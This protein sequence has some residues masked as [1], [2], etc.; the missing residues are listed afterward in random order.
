[1]ATNND[2]LFIN[3]VLTSSTSYGTVSV[4]NLFGK[5]VFR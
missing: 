5:R 1:M 2:R 4:E 3:P